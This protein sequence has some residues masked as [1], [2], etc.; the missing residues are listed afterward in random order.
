M[1]RT[2]LD[3]VGVSVDWSVLELWQSIGAESPS[4]FGKG[5]LFARILTYIL[6][7]TS[8][9]SISKSRIFPTFLTT[10]TNFKM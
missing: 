4:G 3:V 1:L 8:T 5:E 9:Y 6:I 2:E 10:Q 7:Q